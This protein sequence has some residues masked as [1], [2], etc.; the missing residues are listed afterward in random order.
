[1]S[2]AAP[3]VRSSGICGILVSGNPVQACSSLSSEGALST[4]SCLP[5]V[6]VS[7]GN[8]SF[9]TKVRHAQ[10]AGFGAVVVSDD[11]DHSAL[12]T[13]AGNAR[14]ISIPAVFISKS[15]GEALSQYTND[16]NTECWIFPSFEN[17]A[18]LIMIISFISLLTITAM[19]STYFITR[20]HRR[21][22]SGSRR[23]RDGHGM[24]YRLVKAMPSL[25]Y[26]C[27]HDEDG[28][29][30]CAICLEDYIYGAKLRILPCH[31][32]FHSSCIDA[33]LT[34]WRTFCPVCKRDARVT[35]V[36]DTTP[37]L[38]SNGSPWH[39]SSSIEE[40]APLSSQDSGAQAML[41][42]STNSNLE[43]SLA[44]PTAHFSFNQLRPS[45]SQATS[46]ETRRASLHW[47]LPSLGFWGT[48]ANHIPDSL[49]AFRASHHFTPPSSLNSVPNIF[50]SG[51]SS[52]LDSQDA[53]GSF[54]EP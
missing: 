27:E 16:S 45:R 31:H 53:F 10:G 23:H 38:N 11:M 18:W 15:A 4:A 44:P 5:F 14:G 8:C 32:R 7:R 9:E 51:V 20:H 43:S 25:V 24:S 52:H 28:A 48:S 3:Q 33:W 41:V 17:S 34:M 19:L 12:V 21:R 49:D 22:R 35:M 29:D 13:M 26:K 50:G 1:M 2:S 42:N 40:A 47:S 37:L 36:T 54:V 46:I 6:L 39:T 30:T